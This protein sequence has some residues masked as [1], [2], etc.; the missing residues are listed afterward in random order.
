VIPPEYGELASG[1]VGEGRLPEP[2]SLAQHIEVFLSESHVLIGKKA[3]VTAG[4]TYESIDA[5]RF[6]GNRSSGKMGFALADA[7]AQH[8]AEV[9]L[10]SGPTHQ[11]PKHNKVQWVKIETAEEMYTQ[12]QEH[13][14]NSDLGIFAA[15]VADYRPKTVSDEK[16]KKTEANLILALEKT[17][18]SLAWAGVHK[19]NGQFL[20]GFALETHNGEQ[21]AK[22]KIVR[23]NLDA[24]AL[25]ELGEF[26]V[27]F[28]TDT[29]KVCIF[30]KDG[31]EVA[32]DLNTKDNIA[33]GIVAYIIDNI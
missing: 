17:P 31:R 29:N 26:G 28:N 19:T 30:G 15:A 1:M 13:W 20:M 24:V 5:V 21:Y 9:T 23:K 8:G 4:P 7:L 16:I 18:D 25:N 14:P 32:L 6:I 2:E 22:D 27:G 12:T 10:L 11:V 3:L 33:Q